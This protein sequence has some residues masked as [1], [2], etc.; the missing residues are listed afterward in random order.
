MRPTTC[1]WLTPE[2]LS[3]PLTHSS[4]LF[5]L[6]ISAIWRLQI[7]LGELVV[8]REHHGLSELAAAKDVGLSSCCSAADGVVGVA[9]VLCWDGD[10]ADLG[11]DVG[12]VEGMMPAAGNR[13]R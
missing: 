13:S 4:L 7:E 11:E 2:P 6:P 9:K 3:S 8:V 10:E 12:V 5:P 1:G